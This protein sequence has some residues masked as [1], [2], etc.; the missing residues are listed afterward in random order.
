MGSNNGKSGLGVIWQ[1]WQ[2][3]YCYLLRVTSDAIAKS[4]NAKQRQHLS[5]TC[6]FEEESFGS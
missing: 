1:Y 4:K 2:A 5:L 6:H 3:V